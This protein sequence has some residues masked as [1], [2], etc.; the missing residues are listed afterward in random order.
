MKLCWQI[1]DYQGM[2][3]VL[4]RKTFHSNMYSTMKTYESL[5]EGVVDASPSVEK[6]MHLQD[7][8]SSQMKTSLLVNSVHISYKLKS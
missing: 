8:D 7:W 3:L 2:S 1:K 6:P 5:V 4:L